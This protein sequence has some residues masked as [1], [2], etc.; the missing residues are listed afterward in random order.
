VR[1]DWTIRLRG[2]VAEACEGTLA[3]ELVHALRDGVPPPFE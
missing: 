1:K 3:P 2:P